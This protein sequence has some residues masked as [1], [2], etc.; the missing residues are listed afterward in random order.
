MGEPN[1]SSFSIHGLQ[2]C[3]KQL[4]EEEFQ[5]FKDLLKKNT[6]ELATCSFP[7]VEVDNA[8]MEHLVYLLHEHCRGPL[9]WKISMSIYEEMN[10]PALSQKARDAMESK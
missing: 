7:W 10:L 8:N 5:T 9:V 3:F 4:S 6:S 2:W 1:L